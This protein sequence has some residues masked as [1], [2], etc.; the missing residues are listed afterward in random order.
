MTSKKE[1][2]PKVAETDEKQQEN[3]P[4]AATGVKETSSKITGAK[5]NLA[6]IEKQLIKATGEKAAELRK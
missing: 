6:K 3:E 5:L 4:I 2:K 1:K